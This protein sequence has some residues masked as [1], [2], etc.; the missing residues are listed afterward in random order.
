MNLGLNDIWATCLKVENHILFIRVPTI[1]TEC[2]RVEFVC[3]IHPWS[4]SGVG[5]L[6]YT[7]LEFYHKNFTLSTLLLPIIVTTIYNT[8]NTHICMCSVHRPRILYIH[9]D[10]HG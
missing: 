8:Y 3:K 10:T 4:V 6:G 1:I 9:R 5:W 2:Q 7:E